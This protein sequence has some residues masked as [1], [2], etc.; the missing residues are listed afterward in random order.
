[1]GIVDKIFGRRDSKQANDHSDVQDLKQIKA[2]I[3]A[4]TDD[5]AYKD[6]QKMLVKIGEP[7]VEP[8]IETLHSENEDIL[9]WA[10]RTLGSIGDDRAVGPLIQLYENPPSAR[11]RTAAGLS[12]GKLGDPHAIPELVEQLQISNFITEV[13]SMLLAFG[14][15]AVEQII[16]FIQQK[17]ETGSLA[18][19]ANAIEMLGNIGDPRAEEILRDH[20]S[21]E[22]YP[23]NINNL[24]AQALAK[25]GLKIEISQDEIGKLKIGLL[26]N[27]YDIRK[28]TLDR[29]RSAASSI[30]DPEFHTALQASEKIRFAYD[31]QVQA[32]V[33]TK[34]IQACLYAI[35]LE[36]C[37]SAAY[38]CLSYLYR[39]YTT[40]KHKAVEWIQKAIE[41]DPG[42]M[43]A[44]TEMGMVYVALGDVPAAVRAFH[45]Q[46]SIAPSQRNLEPHCRMAAVYRKLNMPNDLAKVLAYQSSQGVGLDP[47]A[48]RE[49]EQMVMATDKALLKQAI[50]GNI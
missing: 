5:A 28:T 36:P 45:H 43:Q 3:S 12:L 38:A 17:D 26:S 9:W 33:N 14:P 34:P 7:A 40:E 16:A 37:F 50:D 42:N 11:I 48:E 8:L 13:K 1:M 23:E 21:S 35:E 39:Q 15:A 24:A 32:A 25:L 19:V 20:T 4:L 46:I 22:K 6:A 30:D 44:W 27:D 49:W 10:A 31:M 41:I 18:G 47:A 2:L 29:A